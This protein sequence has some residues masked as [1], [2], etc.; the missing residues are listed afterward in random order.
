MKI[1]YARASTQ[2]QKLDAQMDAL[3]AAS[4]ER[5]FADVA[6][7]TKS[8]GPNGPNAGTIAFRRYADHPAA[9]PAGSFHEGPS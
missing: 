7:G 1:G 2:D 8:S 9:G 6:S 3:K 5:I 4:A